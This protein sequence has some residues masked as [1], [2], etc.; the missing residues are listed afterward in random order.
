MRKVRPYVAQWYECVMLFIPSHSWSMVMWL[1]F[2][3][4]TLVLCFTPRQFQSITCNKYWVARKVKL[5]KVYEPHVGEA[6]PKQVRQR[7]VTQFWSAKHAGFIRFV[8]SK[9]EMLTE[10]ILV[11]STSLTVTLP[12][13]VFFRL[14]IQAFWHLVRRVVPCLERPCVRWSKCFD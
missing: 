1:Y 5:Q 13:C 6:L 2:L 3:K 10:T 9:Q 11:D 12:S 4:H 8:D 7:V 14:I